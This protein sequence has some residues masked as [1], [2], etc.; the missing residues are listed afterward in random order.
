MMHYAGGG[1]FDAADTFPTVGIVGGGKLG[2][3]LAMALAKM[4]KLEWMLV[5]SAT[6]LETLASIVSS[7][8]P[9]LQELDYIP[10]PPQ[11]IILAVPDSA[12][13]TVAADIAAHFGSSLAGCTVVHCSGAYSIE[14]LT[15]CMM[16]GALCA[17][18]HP[19]QTFT[20]ETDTVLRGIAWGIDC[21]ND[22]EDFL[23]GCIMALGGTPII[24]SE[25]TRQHKAQYH[26]AAV[27][28]SNFLVAAITHAKALAY[29]AGIEPE[30]FLPPII[31]TAVENCLN[32][33]DA[34]TTPL[35]GPISR[36]DAETVSRHLIALD[37]DKE[38]RLSYTYFSNATATIAYSYDMISREQYDS[39]RD[40]LRLP[41]S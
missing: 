31:L 8:V 1:V 29:H 4:Q 17:A 9:L 33:L 10:H 12:I 14:P 16:N 25:H 32:T 35:T 3:T 27:A 34:E 26:A 38:I 39:L 23:S 18:V 28:A 36:G 37:D 21:M 24:L 11:L 22:S 6:R 19:F 40:V 7:E 5:R 30:V 41:Q 15:E 13:E 20:G 2:T